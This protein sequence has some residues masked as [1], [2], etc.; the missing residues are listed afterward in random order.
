MTEFYLVMGMHRSGT[1]LISGLL[2]NANIDMGQGHFGNIGKDNPKG[3]FEDRRFRKMNDRMLSFSQYDVKSWGTEIPIISANKTHMR[4]ISRLLGASRG[5]TR[6]GFKDPRTCLTWH[7]W[8]RYLPQDTTVVYV[9]RNPVSVANSLIKRGNITSL[10]NG[11][12][13]WNIYNKRALPIRRHFKTVFVQ[14]EDVLQDGRI[15]SLGIEDTTGL[16]D[17]S[18]H[19]N[20]PG[21]IPDECQ[22]IWATLKKSENA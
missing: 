19:R 21:N 11:L 3:Y 13:L 10:L 7:I 4:Q 16:V 5:K 1:S 15:P 17:T 2:H 18:L 20:K 9:Y 8:R 6:R 22:Q 12:R 14:Y